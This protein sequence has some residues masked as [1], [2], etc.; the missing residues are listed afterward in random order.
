MGT[1]SIR[2]VAE[3]AGVSVGTVSN[4]LN[5][6]DAVAPA[7]RERVRRAIDDLG[8]VRNESARHL[9]AGRSRTLGLVVL[10][11]TNPFFTDVA[12]GVEDAANEAGLAVILCNSDERR[13]KEQAYLDLLEEQRVQGVLITPVDVDGDRLTR[14]RRRGVPVVLLDRH[15][16]EGDYCSVAVDDVLGGELAAAHL[17]DLGHERIAYVS[18]P[19]SLAQCAD[20]YRGA[21]AGGELEILA[22]TALNVASGRD[23]GER[24]LGLRNPPT[25][26]FCANDLLALGVLQVM[27]ARG[28][29]VPGDISIVGYDDIEFA[30]AAA[31]PLS[32]VR[33]PRHLLGRTAAEL[34]VAEAAAAEPGHIHRQVR[35]SPE[36]VVRASSGPPKATL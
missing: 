24:L 35:F 16:G 10:D 21:I 7:T 4:V 34:L 28:L 1:T 17:R 30:A 2:E 22:G 26:V 23:A 20:R 6:P 5:R 29:S 33:Q 31:V 15:A 25:A 14:L 12:R 9:R 32:S 18:G 3:R 13:D 8:F 27:V 11:V 36:L 19:M